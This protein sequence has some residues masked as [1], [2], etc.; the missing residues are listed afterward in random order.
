M[1]ECQSSGSPSW[2]GLCE[3]LIV[4]LFAPMRGRA[5]RERVS[6]SGVRRRFA[7]A[8]RLRRACVSLAAASC[9]GALTWSYRRERQI[10][11][12]KPP[13]T[14][15]GITGLSQSARPETPNRT[16]SPSPSCAEQPA[17]FGFLAAVVTAQGGSIIHPPR[18]RPRR[19]PHACQSSA[20]GGRRRWSS[21]GRRDGQRS[22][23]PATGPRP[24]GRT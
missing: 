16:C 24:R 17:I 6:R 14:V 23:P 4:P 1:R 11:L 3:T 21:A 18:R 22:A 10:V 8:V 20:G 9:G 12:L 19:T 2:S 5:R 13:A 7:D 15:T